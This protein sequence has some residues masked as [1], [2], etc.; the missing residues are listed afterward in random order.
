MRHAFLLVVLV[1]AGCK[2][3]STD[4]KEIA[5]IPLRSRYPVDNYPMYEGSL[6]DLVPEQVGE[7]TRTESKEALNPGQALSTWSAFY[8]SKNGAE[9]HVRI[10]NYAS[11]EQAYNGFV[12]DRLG[13]VGV[14][15]WKID[16]VVNQHRVIGTRAYGRYHNAVANVEGDSV[17]WTHG[18]LVFAISSKDG[19]RA[20]KFRQELEKGIA[21]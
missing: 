8:R 14:H 10:M 17:A 9:I 7:F 5:G 12:M 13:A 2:P 21:Y 19:V 11:P 16:P 18:T 1:V 15:E 6:G 4:I 3:G 20:E